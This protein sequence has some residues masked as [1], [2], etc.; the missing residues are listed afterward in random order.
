MYQILKSQKLN[1]YLSA[2]LT[3]ARLRVL[4]LGLGLALCAPLNAL[5]L[6]SEDIKNGEFMDKAHEYQ[7]FGCDGDNLSPELSWSEV[8]ADTKAF[9]L[10][11]YDPDAPTGSGWWHWQLVNIPADV[12][13]LPR[14]AGQEGSKLLP[15]NSVQMRNDY[16][17]NA[18]G[19]A[20]PPK[21]HGKHR[22]QFTLYALSTPLQLPEQASAALVGYMVKAHAI[23]EA[24]I[25]AYYQID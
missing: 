10:L 12:R 18:F 8:P 21:G 6:S 7:G 20:C 13:H 1:F 23:D 4:T 16:G 25:E 3:R 11:A 22:Y 15:D 17:A 9:A 5:E 14:G 19:G 24:S 2:S